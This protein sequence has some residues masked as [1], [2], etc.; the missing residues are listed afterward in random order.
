MRWPQPPSHPVFSTKPPNYLHGL[1]YHLHKIKYGF[2]KPH[3]LIR[4][5]KT[6]NNNNNS[7]LYPLL[8]RISR[9][10]AIT[11]QLGGL[12]FDF[13]HPD[14]LDATTDD[15][16]NI[17]IFSQND[18]LALHPSGR[19]SSARQLR[20][21]RHKGTAEDQRMIAQQQYD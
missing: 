12:A 18:E 10:Q 20:V 14:T 16:K 8:K 7:N 1:L 2:L 13:C 4:E 21:L 19:S 17:K 15:F 3:S 9:L 6:N 11:S 5:T